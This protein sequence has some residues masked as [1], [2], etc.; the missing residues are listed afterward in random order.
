VYHLV[1]A[2]IAIMRAPLDDPLMADFVAGVDE[3]DA[4]AQASPGFVSQPTS[5][6]EGTVYTGHSML[7]LSIWEAVEDLERFT[8]GSQHG[9]MLERRA[10]WFHQ[11]ARPNY[12]L[13]WFPEGQVPT[14]REVQARIEHLAAS[15]ATPHAFTFDQRF[16]VQEMLD[17]SENA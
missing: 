4:L 10:E 6:D 12:V 9:R 17:D 14:E 5:A 16:S 15:G 11:D 2:N 7:N 3:I 8:Y 1:H 13:F